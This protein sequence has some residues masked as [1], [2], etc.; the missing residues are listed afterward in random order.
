MPSEWE[1]ERNGLV[2]QGN[3][4]RHLAKT[5]AD[6]HDDQRWE[7]AAKETGKQLEALRGGGCLIPAL[8]CAGTIL[9]WI[10]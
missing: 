7:D 5:G 2:A 6:R 8:L 9:I 1:E 3:L 4:F 10:L